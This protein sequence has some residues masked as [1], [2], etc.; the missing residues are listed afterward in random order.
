MPAS[1]R[2][3]AASILITGAASGIGRSTALRAAR[4]GARIGALDIDA[5][6]LDRL[7]AEIGGIG[8]SCE[9]RRA[10]VAHPND[11]AAAIH[12]LGVA[13]DGFTGVFA[14]AG[15]LTN[16]TTLGELDLVEWNRVLAV[17]LTGVVVTFQAAVEHIGER[18]GALLACGSSLAIRPGT[19]LLA[20]VAA[21]AAVHAVVR[22]LALE[23]ADR[24]ITVNAI[25]PGL[26]DTPMTRAI[27]EHIPLGLDSVPM[28]RLVDIDDVAALAA[29][30][31]SDEARSITGSVFSVD[32][33]RTAV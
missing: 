13:L 15:T 4:E 28:R 17:D 9:T 6:G 30:L 20:Y 3:S 14:N 10:D 32:A 12:E 19:G 26:T 23:L 21:K 27:A 18:G 29:H 2:F 5:E 24:A 8:A 7:A 33:G 25:A 22:S 11:C 16:R 31:L 1:G